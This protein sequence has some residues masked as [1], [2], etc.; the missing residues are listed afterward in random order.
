M[1][2]QIWFAQ[3]LWV[4]QYIEPAAS[5]VPLV[6][7]DLHILDAWCVDILFHGTQVIEHGG[8]EVVEEHAVTFSEAVVL[9]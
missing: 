2:I 3:A 8:L 4:E 5:S 1:C 6:V 9:L 7:G